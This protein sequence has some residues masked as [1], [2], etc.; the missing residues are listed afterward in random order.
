MPALTYDGRSFMLDGRRL[1]LVAGAVH[2]ARIPRELWRDRLLSARAAGLNTI[3]APVFWHRHEARPG[4]FDFKGDNDLR[5]FV[6]LIGQLGMHCVLKPGPYVGE[7]ADAGGLPAWLLA[8]GHVPRR[9]SG[10]FLE[11]CSRYLTKVADQVR[12]LQ[13]TSPKGGPVVLVQ[14]ESAWTCGDDKAAVAYLGELNRY[15]REAGFSVPILNTHN[16]WQG[17]EGEIDG[18]SGSGDMLSTV[19]QLAIVRPGQPRLVEMRVGVPA[20]WGVDDSGAPDPRAVQHRLAQVLAGGG[21]FAVCPFHGGTN[22]GLWGGRTLDGPAGF[23]AASHDHHAPLSETGRRGPLFHA[24]RRIATFASRFGRVLANLDPSFQPIAAAPASDGSSGTCIVHA[25]GSQG[26]VAFVFADSGGSGGGAAKLLLANGAT[27]PVPLPAS[28]V[29]AAAWCLFGASLG[30][31]TTLDYCN[32]S[33]F[34]LVGRVFVCFG[35]AGAGAH[36]SIGGAPLQ[37]VVPSGKAPA[38]IEHEGVVVVLAN[39]EQIDTVFDSA[40]AVYLGV[41]G[42]D[43]AGKPLALPHSRHA[44]RIGADGKMSEVSASPAPAAAWARHAPSRVNLSHWTTAGTQDYADGSSARFA[45]VPGPA[46]LAGL[47]APYGLGWYRV[48]FKPP[49]AGRTVLAFPGGGD[50]LHVYLDGEEMGVAGLG[51]GATRDL[52]VT[53]KR[54]PQTLVVLAENLGRLS[55]GASLGEPRGL[56]GHAW[57]VKPIRAGRPALATGEPVDPLSFR[58]PLWEVHAGDATHPERVTWT[59]RHKH[60]TPI[61]VSFE[62]FTARGLLVVNGKAVRFLERG[63]ADR[64]LLDPEQLSRGNNTIQVALL[65]EPVGPGGEIADPA[66]LL[67]SFA[68]S[69]EFL[70]GVENLTEK[71]EWAFARWEPPTASHFKKPGARRGHAPA[72][73]KASFTPADT[74]APLFF[75]ATGLTKGQLSI[76]GRHVARYFVATGTGRTVPPQARYYVPRPWVTPDAENGVLIVDEH[77]ADP[78][79]CRFV[80]DTGE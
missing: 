71:G 77:G 69:V 20:I 17:I 45:S 46:E 65:Q 43:A 64:V 79:K 76:N 38:V 35:P 60:K 30:G 39:E 72:W 70:E 56:V 1:W 58:T 50:R 37:T 13:A 53:L 14:N 68:E 6:E 61:L 80:Y 19:R 11:A 75:D 31:R 74:D 12:D 3:V 62:R 21:Q 55:E 42:L 27:L 29:Q 78:S 57:A 52:T 2:Y 15:L 33:A 24:V 36:L 16:L 66:A 67:K 73:W 54:R 7:H 49:S 59:I 9:A 10:S 22:F 63:S 23:V 18:W 51:P 4:T 34:T 25:S 8:A 40:D 48:K 47:G 28:P 32:L 41:S 5:H 26:G 44:T